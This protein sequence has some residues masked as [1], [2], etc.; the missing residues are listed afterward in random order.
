MVM[1]PQKGEARHFFWHAFAAS[2]IV[3]TIEE[4]EGFNT[5]QHFTRH[6]F[7][8]AHQFFSSRLF[9][10][11]S[12][13]EFKGVIELILSCRGGWP[14]PLAEILV[15]QAPN[16]SV[17][18]QWV[19]CYA[20]GEISSAPHASA[21][22]FLKQRA[23]SRS[24]PVRLQ[25]ALARFK[26]FV[27]A[28]GLFR[29]NHRGQTREDYDALV[30]SLVRPMSEPE[31]LVC[32][33]AFASILSGPGVGS[34]SPPFLSNYTALQTQI[35]ALCLPLLQDDQKNSKTTTLKELIQTNDYV[36]VCVLVALD[37]EHG[38]KHPLHAMLI[39]NCCNGSIVT[40]GHDQAARHLAICFLLK[41][42]H[43]TAFEIADATASR[44]PD[45]VDIQIL[46]V[47]I[48]GDTPGLEHEAAQRVADLR[49]AYKLTA[50]LETRVATIETE[51]AKRR[52]SR[53]TH[54]AESAW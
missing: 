24:W 4:V 31:H 13:F 23:D 28:E 27:K 54:A 11:L 33:L 26:T 16:A 25:A 20:L 29:I 9:A 42:D 34:F 41:K 37:L 47:E 40:A 45:W 35:E 21:R 8:K 3:E 7:R 49:R 52:D 46:V 39:D 30:G 19:I 36:G 5:G 18:R 51:I 17:F 44:N 2:Q 6:E 14:Y 10:G 15:R 48:L 22:E 12:D 50:E 1:P 43:R 32:L 53:G 38:D